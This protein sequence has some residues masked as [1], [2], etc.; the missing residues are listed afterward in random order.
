MS[1]IAKLEQYLNEGKFKSLIS[2]EDL[3]ALNHENLKWFTQ[4]S[5][6]QVII[7]K[8]IQLNK[9]IYYLFIHGS[10]IKME[11]LSENEIAL[12]DTNNFYLVGFEEN[13]L[14]NP[15]Y[16][17]IMLRYNSI[18]NGDDESSLVRETIKSLLNKFYSYEEKFLTKSFNTLDGGNVTFL[19]EIFLDHKNKTCGVTCYE[20]KTIEIDQNTVDSFR[21]RDLCKKFLSLYEL[22]TEETESFVEKFEHVF[23]DDN[24]MV[25]W[26]L[27]QQKKD[28]PN[29]F[30]VHLS[31]KMGP[32]MI[33]GPKNSSELR[34]NTFK[35]IFDLLLSLN[36]LDYGRYSELLNWMSVGNTVC[37]VSLF[38]IKESED[39]KI[40][41]TFGIGIGDVDVE[42]GLFD[43]L[44]WSQGDEK[45]NYD[46]AS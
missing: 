29:Y 37:E 27:P 40:Q 17:G 18:E 21:H 45:I 1:V 44:P 46:S 32:H 38:F 41:T 24:L 34:T 8:N 39:V 4:A 20:E 3:D 2:Q 9:K 42:Q 19:S 15:I 28:V 12:L 6:S 13:D 33:S 43:E 30:K 7:E 23:A 10:P 35:N 14:I 16:E 26:L 36:I 31:P 22:L 25:Y 5:N 11:D